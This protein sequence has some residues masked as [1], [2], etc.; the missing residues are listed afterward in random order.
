MGRVKIID[1]TM[2]L[3]RIKGCLYEM[4]IHAKFCVKNA[5]IECETDNFVKFNI[6]IYLTKNGEAVLEVQRRK[7]CCMQYGYVCKTILNTA[8][9]KS[10]KSNSSAKVFSCS[11]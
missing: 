10:N 2:V 9:G 5:R 3:E 11:N 1:L 7:G 8:Q 6:N 4:S